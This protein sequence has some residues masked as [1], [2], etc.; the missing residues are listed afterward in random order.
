MAAPILPAIAACATV[1]LAF[2]SAPENLLSRLRAGVADNIRLMPRYTCVQTVNRTRY[3]QPETPRNCA[4]AVALQAKRVA[5]WRD[6]LRLDVAVGETGDLYSWV[7]ASRFDSDEV[8]Q[9]VAQG[10]SASGEFS[11]LLTGVFGGGAGDFRFLGDRDT[12]SGK[13]PS[14]SFVT[15]LARSHYSY[16]T[17]G[18]PV[19]VGY[20]GTFV[21][22][23]VSA[24]LLQLR[25]EAENLPAN[26]CRIASDIEYARSKIGSGDFLLPATSTVDVLHLDGSE[27]RNETSYSGCRAYMGESTIQFGGD[28]GPASPAAAPQI[29]ASSP[30]PLPPRTRLRVRIAPPVDSK[31]AAAGDPIVGVID[32]QVRDKG[33]I[34]VNAG[35]TLHGRILRL[36]QLL[37]HST[38]LTRLPDAQQMKLGM[39]C[40]QCVP[41][42]PDMRPNWVVTMLFDTL[43]SGGA[44]QKV[45]L[46]AVDDGYRFDVPRGQIIPD[47]DRPAGGGIFVFGEAGDLVLG[48]KF[49]STWETQ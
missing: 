34:L 18:G 41:Q 42:T 5:R 11:G 32:A 25:V 43:E 1:V 44:G 16:G 39:M 35:D 14:Y 30:P 6:R 37:P 4:D 13:F 20:H 38:A 47:S 46:K 22:D 3:E 12:P 45:M 48:Q 24:D 19:T 7:G 21:A 27:S 8:G 2:E 9:L 49:A 36:E 17:A 31:I 26:V 15:P 28:D 29:A 10:M 23:P 33:R 40:R